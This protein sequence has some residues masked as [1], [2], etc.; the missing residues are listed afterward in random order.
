MKPSAAIAGSLQRI[1][2]LSCPA[3]PPNQA[4]G[5]NQ[6]SLCQQKHKGSTMG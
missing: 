3:E 1:A 5:A 6:T 2:P 4:L